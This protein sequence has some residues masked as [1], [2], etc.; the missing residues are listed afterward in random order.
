MDIETGIQEITTEDITMKE[1][2]NIKQGLFMS[3]RLKNPNQW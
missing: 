2:R 1:D 3:M